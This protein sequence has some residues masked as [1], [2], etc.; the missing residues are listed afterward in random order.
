MSSDVISSSTS[1]S[2]RIMAEAERHRPAVV[3]LLRDVIHTPSLSGGEE[4]VVARLRAEMEALGFDELIED[5]FGSA[6]GRIGSGPVKIVYDSHIDTV[7]V[8]SRAE[9]SRDP[10]EPALEGD[11]DGGVVHG[12]GASDNKAGVASM[13]H[14]AALA[15]DLGRLEGVS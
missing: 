4:D 14:G 3:E 9:W 5:P 7:D 6:V 15:R 13:I 1:S 2:G 8:G 12:R 10:F 11:L